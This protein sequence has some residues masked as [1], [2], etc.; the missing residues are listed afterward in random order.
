MSPT[1]DA[2]CIVH[3]LKHPQEGE[4]IAEGKNRCLYPRVVS[5]KVVEATYAFGL[6]VAGIRIKNLTS[7]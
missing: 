2:L 6:R 5:N 1:A 4:A 7:P 3:S